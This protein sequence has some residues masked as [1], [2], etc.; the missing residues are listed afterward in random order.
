MKTKTS[1]ENKIYC[2]S[3]GVQWKRKTKLFTTNKYV[4]AK[5][6][7]ETRNKLL[8]VFMHSSDMRSDFGSRQTSLTFRGN[9]YLASTQFVCWCC[10]SNEP[11]YTLI[12]GMFLFFRLVLQCLNWRPPKIQHWKMPPLWL[13]WRPAVRVATISLQRSPSVPG[14]R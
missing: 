2:C 13:R 5:N 1:M 3:N 10:E 7:A 8:K 11:N 12:L 4:L 9:I 6:C 14:T